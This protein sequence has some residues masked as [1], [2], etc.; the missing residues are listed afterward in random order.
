[1]ADPYVESRANA[2]AQSDNYRSGNRYSHYL[3]AAN[4]FDVSAE[5]SSFPG[6]LNDHYNV[7]HD[8]SDICA[9]LL[10][11]SVMQLNHLQ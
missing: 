3:F 7:T 4:T 8:E 10:C 6:N 11:N 9:R 1:M 2:V 5:R